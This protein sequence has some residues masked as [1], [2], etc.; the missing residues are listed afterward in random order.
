MQ[1]AGET[2]AQ[3]TGLRRLLLDNLLTCTQLSDI[4][5]LFSDGAFTC[6]DFQRQLAGA[7][8]SPLRDDAF[9]GSMTDVSQCD[10]C[11]KLRKVKPKM[12]TCAGCRGYHY[13]DRACQKQHWRD[14]HKAQCTKTDISK[15]HFRVTDACTKLFSVM[16]MWHDEDGTWTVNATNS[17]LADKIRSKGFTNHIYVPI[18]MFD[19]VVYV[20]MPEAVIGYVQAKADD[21]TAATT[22]AVMQMYEYRGSLML[23]VP[24]Q[25]PD[26]H[27][28][29]SLALMV[30][31]TFV[32]RP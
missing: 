8:A 31:E 29:K 20:P 21:T 9:M 17:P 6:A 2:S 13:C 18:S 12:M 11:G 15:T 1:N 26:E 3:I 30:K 4:L 5:R 14:S 19:T 23:L 22:A 28:K 16:S 25:V 24:T 27:G 32:S 7:I 10:Q